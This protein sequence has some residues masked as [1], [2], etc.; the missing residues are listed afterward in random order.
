MQMANFHFFSPTDTLADIQAINKEE[1]E[2][3]HA[4]STGHAKAISQV[5]VELFNVNFI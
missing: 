2:N 5:Q 3:I 4:V 1:I